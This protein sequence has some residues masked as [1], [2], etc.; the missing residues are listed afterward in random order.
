MVKNQ[1]NKILK[2]FLRYLKTNFFILIED[3]EGKSKPL[4]FQNLNV[5]RMRVKD[6]A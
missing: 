1:F 4:D 6:R 3:L 2:F 5:E